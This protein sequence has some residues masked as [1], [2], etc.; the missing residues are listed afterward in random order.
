MSVTKRAIEHRRNRHPPRR[1]RRK[2]NKRR[3]IQLW[4]NVK[5]SAAYHGLS[6]TAR[7]ALVE[8]LD[9]YNGVN[10][11]MIGLGAR[12][13]ADELGCSKDTANRA[14]HEIDDAGLAHPTRVGVWRGKKAT[15]WGLTFYPNNATGEP[16]TA[17]WEAA[18]SPISGTQSPISGTQGRLQSE[19]R[20]TKS[21][22]LNDSDSAQSDKRD[23][24]RYTPHTKDVSDTGG[25]YPPAVPRVPSSPREGEV[26]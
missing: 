2:I 9:R 7:A 16:A 3:F 5:R 6:C 21:K 15:E 26:T 10:N 4:T 25:G 20:D 13:L 12:E 23:T 11:G 1:E 19:V 17:V 14:L 24:Y 22:K 8:L 18:Y